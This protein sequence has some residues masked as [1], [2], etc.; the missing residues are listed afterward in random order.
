[1]GLLIIS[2]TSKH[3]F[4]GTNEQHETMTWGILNAG[5]DENCKKIL[6]N[7]GYWKFVRENRIEPTNVIP[8]KRGVESLNK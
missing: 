6:N 8:N 7:A 3:F 4:R 2:E 1:M 5:L